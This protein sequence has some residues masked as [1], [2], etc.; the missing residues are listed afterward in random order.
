[1]MEAIK[2]LNKLEQKDKNGLSTLDKLDKLING[3]PQI[4]QRL[5][6]MEEVIKNCE[7]IPEINGQLTK[8]IKEVRAINETL[9]K[10]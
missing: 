9:G 5:E 1:M 10:R 7:E 3:F 4:M 2:F 8:L 6:D